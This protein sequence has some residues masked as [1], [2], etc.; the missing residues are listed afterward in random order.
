MLGTPPRIR[1]YQTLGDL[2]LHFNYK[3]DSLTNYKS[4][5]VLPIPEKSAIYFNGKRI[6]NY[7]GILNLLPGTNL[8]SIKPI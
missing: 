5:F 4:E 7:I 6:N 8:I 1:S 3:Q 2:K